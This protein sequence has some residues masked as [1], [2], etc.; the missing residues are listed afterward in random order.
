MKLFLLLL[1]VSAPS[2]AQIAIRAK[3][4]HTMAG[5]P[6]SDGLVLIQ[7]TTI[8]QVGPAST[9]TIPVGFR[10][11]QA[12]VA[13]PG[14]I[15]GHSTVGL[16]GYLNQ[17]HGQDQFDPS[18]P[19]QP[20]LRAIDSY[21]ARDPLVAWL[22]DHGVTTI[23]TGHAPLSIISGQTI[24]VKTG[25]QTLGDALLSPQAMLTATLGENA[26]RKGKSPPGSRSKM[27]AMLRQELIKASEYLKKQATAESGSQPPRDLRLET[28][29]KA[30]LGETP[31]LITAHRAKDILNTLRLA[32]EFGFKL[33]LDGAAEAYLLIDH[34]KQAEVPVILH[35]TMARHLGELENASMETAALLADAGI[36][37]A[38]QSGYEAYVPRTRVV[39][40]EAALAAAHKLGAERALAAAT[41]H[42]AQI[43]GIAQRVGSLEP[44]KDA[45]LALFDGDPFE[46]RTHVVAV[47]VNGKL[48]EISH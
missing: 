26:L 45:D 35:P 41:L 40:F 30:L 15:D 11:I 12:D 14:F 48:T 27:L 8:Q 22:H 1:L 39:L 20:E 19:I 17:E 16:A 5:P 4:L 25:G 24:I 37:F 36:P 7:G 18:E 38:F 34:L 2:F 6:I 13:T 23:H 47:M 10:L 43:L 28:L 42:A 44:G 9:M 31:V 32:S 3:T 33:I 46:Y 29:G 21:N